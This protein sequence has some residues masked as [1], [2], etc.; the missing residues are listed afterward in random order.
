MP[1]IIKRPQALIDLA[2]IW[3]YIADGDE[4]RADACV[5]CQLADM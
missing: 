3:D 2:E 4:A 5:A 1:V